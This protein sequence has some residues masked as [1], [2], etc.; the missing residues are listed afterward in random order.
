M[1]K[2]NTNIKK[3]L[4]SMELTT[5]DILAEHWREIKELKKRIEVLENYSKK[6]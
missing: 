6:G 4:E 2:C 3:G 1:T 5:N